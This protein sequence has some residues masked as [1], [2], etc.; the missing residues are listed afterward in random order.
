M[1]EH[2]SLLSL[3]GTSDRVLAFP[4]EDYGVIITLQSHFLAADSRGSVSELTFVSV[5]SGSS[6]DLVP[7]CLDTSPRPLYEGPTA[8]PGQV[9]GGRGQTPWGGAHVGDARDHAPT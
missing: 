8:E 9:L 5:S 3:G 2:T 7:V 1:C 6:S 4:G